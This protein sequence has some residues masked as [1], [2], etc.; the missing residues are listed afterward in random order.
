MK[1]IAREDFVVVSYVP[2]ENMFYKESLT[3]FYI[4]IIRTTKMYF[5]NTEINPYNL[6]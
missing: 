4:K 3:F 1:N 5:N 6:K 2:F